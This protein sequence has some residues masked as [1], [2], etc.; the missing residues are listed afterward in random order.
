L[1]LSPPVFLSR[2]PHSLSFLS[3]PP[4]YSQIDRKEGIRCARADLPFLFRAFEAGQAPPPRPGTKRATE[5]R[6]ATI[7]EY[8]D[9]T[10]SA[11]ESTPEEKS[12]AEARR[13]R[14]VAA[15]A[16]EEK[17][18]AEAATAA[19]A[20]ATKTETATTAAPPPAATTTTTTSPIPT[21]ASN[22]NLSF[23]NEADADADFSGFRTVR[24]R[25]KIKKYLLSS[26][27]E[28]EKTRKRAN[29]LTFPSLSL[30]LPGRPPPAL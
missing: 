18:K 27:S 15:A 6:A 4:L 14:A 24:R 3:P 5:A 23:Y 28:R 1:L 30:L 26:A 20:A 10:V 13:V 22:L 29:K 16:E 2:P 17:K 25:R 7:H 12:E 21:A 19:G 11:E 8:L 9:W